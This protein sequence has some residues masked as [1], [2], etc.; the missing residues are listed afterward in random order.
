M[1]RKLRTQK[2][3]GEYNR[4]SDN[5]ETP[6]NAMELLLQFL[7]RDKILWDPFFCKGTVGDVFTRL[8]FTA[9]HVDR[10]FFTYEPCLYEIIV[11]NPP[12]SIKNEVLS[13]LLLIGRPFA[14]LMPITTIGTS[15][16]Y[17]LMKSRPYQVIIPK[18]RINFLRA[19][20]KS[21]KNKACTF[22]TGWITVGLEE[23]LGRDKQIL[24][25]D[26]ANLR[27]R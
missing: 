5:Y 15:Y 14:V 1:M 12:Y 25:L 18:Q 8:G 17:T 20:G 2:R 26:A 16:F 24:H 22:V 13:R 10:D 9:I 27:G 23:F 19:D 21:N 3:A 4:L 7:P 11:T 6:S